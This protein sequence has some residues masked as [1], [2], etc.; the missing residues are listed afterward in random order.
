MMLYVLVSVIVYVIQTSVFG[1]HA[2]FGYHYVDLLPAAVTA[3]ALLDGPVEG[4]VVGSAGVLYDLGLVGVDGLYPLF[5]LLFGY[6]GGLFCQTVLTGGYISMVILNAFEMCCSVCCAIF[7]Q[8]HA[9]RVL[10]A[11]PAS[12]SRQNA[13]RLPVLLY[14]LPAAAA[15]QPRIPQGTDRWIKERPHVK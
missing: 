3:T 8:L 6:A 7:S 2:Q 11:R 15:H 10:P 4:A 14:R 9:G 12:D 1:A 5:F 13:R